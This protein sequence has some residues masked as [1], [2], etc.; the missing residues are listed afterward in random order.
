MTPSKET[1][2]LGYHKAVIDVPSD[3][4]GMDL[5]FADNDSR[6]HGGGGGFVDD[7][8]GLDYH[9]P[10]Q[11]HDEEG[12]A[13]AAGGGGGG[14]TQGGDLS[15]STSMRKRSQSPSRTRTIQCLKI[16]H[17]AVEMAPIAKVGGMGDVVTA[18]GRA[19]QDEGHQVECILPKYDCI[20]YSQVQGLVQEAS[21]PFGG[22]QVKVWKGLVEELPTI[23]LEPENGHF[24]VGCIYGKNNDAQRFG[25]FCGAALEFLKRRGEAMRPDVIHCH[26]WPTAPIAWGDRAGSRCIFTIHNL[27]YGADLVGR[28]MATCE[29]AT[30]VSPTYAR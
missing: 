17:I 11:T 24:W 23:F 12:T 7:N 3:A 4:W 9:I 15:S 18:L 14:L 30:T 20:N 28:A 5:V 21:F 19:V 16:V 25:F 2:G 1:G 26:D 8:G 13:T 6:A 22:T 29:V 10:V 27:S